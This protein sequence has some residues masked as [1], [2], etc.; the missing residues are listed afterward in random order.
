M[1]SKLKAK[2]WYLKNHEKIL[3]KS[4][5]RYRKNRLAILEIRKKYYQ[6]NRKKIIERSK[7]WCKNN[8][9]KQRDRTRKWREKNREKDR[10]S[11]REWGKKHPE[12]RKETS[13]RWREKNREKYNVFQR[14]N[15]AKRKKVEGSFT[16]EEWEQK[17]KKFNYKCAIC[18][19]SEEELLNKTGIGLTI[20]H[21]IPITKKGTNYI[22]NIQPLCFK[23]NRKKSNKLL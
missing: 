9:E 5:E 10:K 11:A 23:C 4:K 21:I 2:E 15:Y 12:Q 6:K 16:I 1:T 8:P 17:K 3:E 7:K 13:K 14:N 22:S 20:D 18:K 19:I